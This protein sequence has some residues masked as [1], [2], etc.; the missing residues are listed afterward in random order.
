MIG[1]SVGPGGPAG[2]GGPPGPASGSRA[3]TVLEAWPVVTLL[4]LA[5][6]AATLLGSRLLAAVDAH[7]SGAGAPGPYLLAA[8]WGVLLGA[9]I[10]LWPAP[11]GDKPHLAVAWL[12]KVLVTLGFMLAYEAAYPFM[13]GYGY[14][15]GAA[16]VAAPSLARFGDGTWLMKLLVSVHLRVLPEGYH[17]VKL[18]FSYLGLV[19]LYV[20]YR[21]A[22]L[23]V[24]RRSLG[25]LYVML[26]FPSLL[27]WSSLLGKEPVALLGIATY[28]Y[29]TA[30]WW[31]LGEARALTWTL[32]GI[33][34]AAA[35]RVWLGPI[36]LFPLA[37]LALWR[38][39]AGARIAYVA[40]FGGLAWWSGGALL[41]RFGVRS[42]EDLVALLSRW[43]QAWARG[44]SAQLLEPFRGI[45]DL[46]AFLPLGVFTALFRPLPG[47]IGHGFGLLAGAENLLLLGAA[48][49][50]VARDRG[51]SLR[52]PLV[53]WAILVVLAWATVYAFLSYQNLG[54]GARFRVQILPLLLALLAIGW[55]G[56]GATAPAVVADGSPSKEDSSQ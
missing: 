24:G 36:L 18:S 28:A 46:L 42:P 48:V 13:D 14:Y 56:R 37:Y 38:A 17:L 27:F 2:E 49:G 50:A 34:L 22:A 8:G 51:R 12:V 7:L 26:L 15:R 31:R 21:A 10:L 40:L 1:A 54:T 25:L 41:A 45:P 53:V 9:T 16:S 39:R 20:G 29:G 55:A 32:A 11:D 4:A 44:G 35:V 33:L 6:G 30:R 5:A 19:G 23:L 43:S 52:D 47:E 3:E